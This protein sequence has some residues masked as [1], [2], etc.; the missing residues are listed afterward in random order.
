MH[1][2]LVGAPCFKACKKKVIVQSKATCS[3]PSLCESKQSWRELFVQSTQACMHQMSNRTKH[4]GHYYIVNH[5][6][7]MMKSKVACRKLLLCESK[8]TCQRTTLN[9]RMQSKLASK[10]AKCLIEGCESKKTCFFSNFVK[11]IIFICFPFLIVSS[12]T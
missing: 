2:G 8:P 6:R 12:L 11:K 5:V 10:K 3:Q 9:R 7:P 1:A 4:A